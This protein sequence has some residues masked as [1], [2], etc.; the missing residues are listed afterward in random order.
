M[1]FGYEEECAQAE[2]VK[3]K[4]LTVYIAVAAAF[5]AA[6][7]LLL[8]LSTDHYTPFMVANILLS[9]AFGFYSVWF[10]TVKY[11]FAVKKYRFLNK[12][13]NALEEKEFA[14][15]LKEEEMMTI[16]G[17]GM[18]ILLFDILG[19]VRE[20][21]LFESNFAPEQNKKYLIVMR[22][23]VIVKMEECNE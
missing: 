10:F 7:L 17:V 19:T 18:R 8:F 15:F 16:D 20:A 1:I 11:D 4:L 9:I 2:K 14:V 23:G 3:K 12:V 21:H 13:S 22:A 5:V 6:V